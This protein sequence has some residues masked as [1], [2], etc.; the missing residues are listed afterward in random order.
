[1]AGGVA[2]TRTTVTS[3]ALKRAAALGGVAGVGG[4]QVLV[5]DGLDR[6]VRVLR[7]RVGAGRRRRECGDREA[8]R[9]TAGKAGHGDS[10]ALRPPG[11]VVLLCTVTRAGIRVE[12]VRYTPVNA[13]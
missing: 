6:I 1:M 7:V 11:A 10:C 13:A 8:Q 12:Y 9:G 4:A 5:G 2:G 3:G